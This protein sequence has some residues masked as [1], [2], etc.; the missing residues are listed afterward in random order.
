VNQRDHKPPKVCVV[1]LFDASEAAAIDT[2]IAAA[3]VRPSR[4]AVVRAALRRG[5]PL[6]VVANA[7]PAPEAA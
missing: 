6:L 4:A 1:V 5:L 7:P 3:P 2:V